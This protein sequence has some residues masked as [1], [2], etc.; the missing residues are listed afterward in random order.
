MNS[1]EKIGLVGAQVYSVYL[2]IGPRLRLGWKNI[3][4]DWV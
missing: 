2:R 1:K 4:H 3:C